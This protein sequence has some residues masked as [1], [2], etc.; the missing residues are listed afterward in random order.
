MEKCREYQIP[1]CTGYIDYMKSFDSI[2]T[3]AVLNALREPRVEG[4]HAKIVE[5]I[6]KEYYEK[7]KFS[8]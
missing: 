6:F 8:N 1:L 7:I 3:V 5:E 4:K 2:V